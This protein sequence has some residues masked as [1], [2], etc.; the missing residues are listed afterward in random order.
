[1][2]ASQFLGQSF[3]LKQFEMVG[4]GEVVEDSEV[5]HGASLTRLISNSN[6]NKWH[7]II[8]NLEKVLLHSVGRRA[9][10][11]HQWAIHRGGRVGCGVVGL[12]SRA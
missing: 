11:P 12:Q 8:L 5:N 7:K 9:Q 3:K 10:G 6:K 1:M 2:L 4:A